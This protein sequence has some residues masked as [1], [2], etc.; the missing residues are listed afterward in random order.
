MAKRK[1]T[2]F[3]ADEADDAFTPTVKTVRGGDVKE[4]KEKKV[5]NVP[6][7]E[8]VVEKAV[9]KAPPKVETAPVPAAEK[10]VA[11]PALSVPPA[12]KDE[13]IN[14]ILKTK[15]S[16]SLATEDDEGERLIQ[17]VGFCLGD[18]EFG[19]DIQEVHEINRTT[20]ITPVPRTP[21]F[22]EGVINLRGKVLPV[23]NMRVRFRLATAEKTNQTR[24]VIVEADGKI[25]G[26]LVDSVTEVLR[27]S[28]ST[29]EPPPDI[30][31]GIDSENIK[32]IAKLENR[33]LILL[34]LA[35]VLSNVD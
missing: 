19:I 30:I 32:G 23:I 26:M 8:P 35:K 28:S 34:D 20:E 6:S 12:K 22:V 33:L 3:S 24:I 2:S 15:A 25:V 11:A 4:K 5:K 10:T 7:P 18:E 14:D 21:D 31:S 16:R 1:L 13:A 17:L 27:I 29:I 9:E